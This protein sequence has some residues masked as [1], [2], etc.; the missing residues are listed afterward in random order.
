MSQFIL[1]TGMP[2]VGKTTIIKK[3]LNDL[4]T[5]NIQCKGFYT[6]EKRN[7][8][9]VRIGFNVTKTDGVEGTLARISFSSEIIDPP[10]TGTKFQ[11]SKYVVYVNEFENMCLKL[12]DCE[13]ENAIIII[14]EVGKMELLSKEFES[15]I[16]NLLKSKKNLRVIATIPLK[17]N[18][19]SIK[20]M[21]KHKNSNLF[22]V[23]NVNRDN[24]YLAILEDVRKRL[25]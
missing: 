2:G 4:T 17:F 8:N 3:L 16:G 24:V 5:N 6:E 13:E 12:V 25:I 20:D 23:T 18:H 14:D 11:V 7:P 15:A 21:K 1:I 22:N 9:N 19:T 10:K